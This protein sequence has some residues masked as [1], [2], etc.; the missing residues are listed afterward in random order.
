MSKVRTAEQLAELI[1]DGMT[2]GVSGFGLAGWNQEMAIAIG[3]RF[4][5]TGHPRDIT[6][7]QS[8]PIGDH[9]E[10]TGTAFLAHEGLIKRW[11]GAHLLGSPK[12]ERLVVENKLEAYNLPQGVII[13]LWREIAAKRPGLFTKVGLKTFVDPRVEGAKL[14]ARTTEDIVKVVNFEGEEWLFYKSFPVDVGLIRGTTAD[15]N[16]NITMENE[17]ILA[18]ALPLAQAVKNSGGIVIAQVENIA[19]ANTLH[20]KDVRVPGI[21]VDYVVVA[22][23][24]KN[25][26]QTEGTYYNP[27]FAGNIKV[28]LSEVAPL[29]LNERKIIARRA[30]MELKPNA[31]LNLGVGIP[32]DVANVAA[33]EKADKSLTLTTEAGSIGGIPASLPHFGHAYNSEC[34]L[35]EQAQFYY[36][37]GGGIDITCLGLAQTDKLGNVN[38]THFG[39]KIAGCGGFM[40]VSQNAKKVIFCG[41]F[42]AGGLKV[43]IEDGKLKIIQE[44][45]YQKFLPQVEHISFSG[46][47][48][49][50]IN[51]PVLYI[52][53]RA[54]FTLENGEMTLIEIAP[55]ID[56]EKD[57]LAHMGFRPRISSNLKE[58]PSGIFQPEWG[59]LRQIIEEKMKG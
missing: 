18:C 29:E 37:D 5:E 15:E 24:Q 43:A 35:E 39:P 50:E 52:T 56:L 8:S 7:V 45:K 46:E 1:Q 2:V 9:T 58:M 19:K 26:Y 44:G 42:T 28:P 25:H 11:I 57:V 20:P 30:A 32:S 31:I 14:N 21:L 40:N 6:F 22:T 38:V 41:T 36:Y 53:E 55:G 13:Q 33:E 49:S 47:Y 10:N 17:G 16:G 4:E 54:V 34:M 12:M 59:Q 3:K 48:A 23:S 27:A 51:K